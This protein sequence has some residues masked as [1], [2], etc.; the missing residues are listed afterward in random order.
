[1]FRRFLP[2]MVNLLKMQRQ[3]DIKKFASSHCLAICYH[4]LFAS[5][6]QIL[7]GHSGLCSKSGESTRPCRQEGILFIWGQLCVWCPSQRV[8]TVT[9]GQAE[10]GGGRSPRIHVP[11]HRH[12]AT[13][14]YTSKIASEHPEFVQETPRTVS[15]NAG[16]ILHSEND[17]IG[18][19]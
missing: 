11:C 13:A 9:W 4:F 5:P 8:A 16:S 7:W 17:Y 10:V 19:I 15:N 1:M 18:N 12:R 3:K 2:I 14:R 6:G